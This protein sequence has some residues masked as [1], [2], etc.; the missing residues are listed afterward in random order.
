MRKMIAGMVAALAILA[1][2]AA[3]ASAAIPASPQRIVTGDG[4][5]LPILDEGH[6]L[7]VVTTSASGGTVFTRHLDSLGTA[8]ELENAADSLCLTNNS[9]QINAVYME[10]CNMSSVATLWTTTPTHLLQS[11]QVVQG[12]AT[13]NMTDVNTNCSLTGEPFRDVGGLPLSCRNQFTV[14]S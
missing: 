5:F 13:G 7:P 9:G 12:G 4:T 14:P 11:V 2:T 1:P 8:F 6:G 3:F 10:S